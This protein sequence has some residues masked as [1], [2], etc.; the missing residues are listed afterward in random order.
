MFLAVS[1]LEKNM[2]HTFLSKTF[3]RGKSHLVVEVSHYRT[4]QYV[5]YSVLTC[6]IRLEDGCFTPEIRFIQNHVQ[7]R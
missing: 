5:H 3:F 6:L 2:C 1:G 4:I 7:E